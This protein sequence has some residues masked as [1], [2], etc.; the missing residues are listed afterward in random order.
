MPGQWLAGERK[1]SVVKGI[2]RPRICAPK[3]ADC[4]EDWHV[5]VLEE[6]MHEVHGT[7]HIV[8]EFDD[9]EPGDPHAKHG[10]E[11]IIIKKSVE[12]EI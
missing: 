3:T 6:G 11:V 2:L 4:D 12:D 10:R 8:K 5:E 1:N 7:L 9:L